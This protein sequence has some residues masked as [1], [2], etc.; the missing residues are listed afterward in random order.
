MHY[1]NGDVKQIIQIKKGDSVKQ[2]E[3]Y[4]SKNSQIIEY[5]ICDGKNIHYFLAND[6]IELND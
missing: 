3:I 2:M 1:I 6:Q 4:F 5:T